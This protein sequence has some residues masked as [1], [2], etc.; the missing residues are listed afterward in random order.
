M[1]PWFCCYEKRRQCIGDSTKRDDEPIESG[2]N[3][4]GD[5]ESR[6]QRERFIVGVNQRFSREQCDVANGDVSAI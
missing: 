5:G 3:R 6:H 2:W 4:L 1:D